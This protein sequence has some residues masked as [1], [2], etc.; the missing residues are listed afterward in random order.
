MTTVDELQARIKELEEENSQL[1]E[2]TEKMA[3]DSWLF[4][5]LMTYIPDWVYFKDRDSRFLSASEA[6]SRS[7]GLQNAQELVGKTDFDFFTEE[8][9]RPAFEDE[10]RIIESGEP[11]TLEEKETRPDGSVGWVLT[12]K[13]PLFRNGNIVGTFGVSKDITERRQIED[14]IKELN[15]A[16]ETR[17]QKRTAE[18]VREMAER[19]KAEEEHTRLQTEVIRA[20]KI[21]LQ[22]LTTPIIPLIEGII[23]MPLV[24]SIDTQRASDVMRTLLSGISQHRANI[25]ILDI[26]GVPIVDTGVANHLNKTMLA[27]RLKGVRVFVTGMSDA[28][29]ET[30]VDLGIDWG[31]IETLR[32]LQSGFV[33]ALRQLG[34]R[35]S[36]A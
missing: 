10:Q 33:H 22:E 27:A 17:V 24:G 19:Q 36:K 35:L 14:E 34:M 26:T 7:F 15:T 4:R 2:K 16:L 8:H 3:V 25:V 32:D 9:A 18:L 5:T 30:I 6:L 20:Q 31:D 13:M 11:I 28:V 23:V 29:A 12:T 21:A 1:R